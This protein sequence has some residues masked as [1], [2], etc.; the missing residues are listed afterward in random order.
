MRA[1]NGRPTAAVLHDDVAPDAPPDVRDGLVQAHEV[2][3]ALGHLGF[4]TRRIPVGADAGRV[5]ARLSA[6]R[7]AV[8]FNLVESLG[9]DGAR[10]HVP[11]A[12]LESLPFPFTGARAAGHVCTGNKLL[13]KQLLTAAGLPT[14]RHAAT[15]AE[16]A[17]WESDQ[18]GIVKPV[19]EDASVAIDSASVAV[20]ATALTRELEAR[21]RRFGGEWFVEEYIAGREFNVSVLGTGAGATVLPVAEIE[22][23]DFPAGRPHIVDYDAKW[24]AD[25]FAYRNTPRRF[26]GAGDDAAL[27]AVLARMALECHALFPLGGYSR[28]DFRVDGAG[29]PYVLEVNANPCLAAD[30][31]FMAAAHHAG[32]DAETVVARIVAAAGVRCSA[33]VHERTRAGARALRD[34]PA[35]SPLRC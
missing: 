30:A 7:P 17:R 25:S 19:A 33:G 29:R 21:A 32:L 1:L 34:A 16:L 14:P 15:A 4:R 12:V 31:G 5:A 27:V 8:V 13:A 2:S 28:V 20:G 6:L 9:G 26:P 23:V 18:A 24:R 22:F 35:R 11:A 10:V 3:V